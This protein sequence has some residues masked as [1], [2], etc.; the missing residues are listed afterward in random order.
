[1]HVC[2]DGF[3]I[4]LCTL[5]SEQ[6][7]F[8]IDPQATHLSLKSASDLSSLIFLVLISLCL[9]TF[10]SELFWSCSHLL[11]AICSTYIEEVIGEY[12]FSFK[13]FFIERFN[14]WLSFRIQDSYIV[15]KVKSEY[16]E[17]HKSCGHGN[18]AF[19]IVVFD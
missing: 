5:T 1:M 15:Y 19:N 2:I 11:I 7:W 4:N 3:T 6:L 10:K 18:D 17:S 16:C 14:Y 9:C 12:L 8:N 13:F